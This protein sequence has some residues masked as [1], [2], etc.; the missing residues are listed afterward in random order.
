MGREKQQQRSKKVKY[1]TSIL[2]ALAVTALVAKADPISLGSASTAALGGIENTA[3]VVTGATFKTIQGGGDVSVTESDGAITVSF[4]AAAE[5]DPVWTADKAKYVQFTDSAFVTATNKAD[6]AVQ[7]VAKASGGASELTVTQNGT[8]V[9]IDVDLSAYAKTEDLY[10]HATDKAQATAGFYKITTDAAGHVTVGAALAA[11]DI[12][13]LVPEADDYNATEAAKVADAGT[14]IA[15]IGAVS[16]S[17][18]STLN[19]CIAA[20][21]AIVAAAAG[22]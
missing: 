14:K 2:S 6:T 12:T 5:T 11:A 21:Q 18:L 10:V 22:N 16:T 1:F 7:T 9:T 8:S 19:E 13:A 17:E 4:S 3:D 20:I 15:A